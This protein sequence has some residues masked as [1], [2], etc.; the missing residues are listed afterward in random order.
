M[1]T[2]C[3]HGLACSF[4]LPA[5]PSSSSS[6]SFLFMLGS[7]HL[8]GHPTKLPLELIFD[9]HRTAWYSLLIL[10]LLTHPCM[11]FT[12]RGGES[13]YTIYMTS[14][15]LLHLQENLYTN[16][17]VS[18]NHM[19][20]ALKL[21]QRYVSEQKC[22]VF[23]LFLFFAFAFASKYLNVPRFLDFGYL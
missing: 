9:D 12:L 4:P 1:R 18:I 15:M 23:L 14:S 16:C 3:E 11:P 2:S 8:C 22:F 5:R 10:P 19:D 13:F 7:S 21:Y 20:S 17:I 6:C